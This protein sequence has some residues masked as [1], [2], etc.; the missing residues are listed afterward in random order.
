M[1]RDVHADATDRLERWRAS[2]KEQERALADKRQREEDAEQAERNS[3]A[4]WEKWIDDKIELGMLHVVKE[5]ATA[6][7]AEFSSRDE[8]FAKMST[9]ASRLELELTQLA[10]SH[11]RLE[12][13]LL[14]AI[15]DGDH[16]KA[17]DLPNMGL[18]KVVN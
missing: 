1:R 9:R 15:A 8:A 16:T 11:A 13:R 5:L 6:I 18:R 3:A 2:V 17:I 10:A 14:Q 12:V 7:A 4:Q